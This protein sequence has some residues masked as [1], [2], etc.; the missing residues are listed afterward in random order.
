MTSTPWTSSGAATST[1][2]SRTWMVRGG[3]PVTEGGTV[4][5]ITGGAGGISRRSDPT[6]PPFKTGSA[7]AT[8]SVT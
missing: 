6:G 7:A 3:K 5:M 4:Y 1:R 2:T 8:T